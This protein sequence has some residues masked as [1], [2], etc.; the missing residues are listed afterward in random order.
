MFDPTWVLHKTYLITCKLPQYPSEKNVNK[1]NKISYFNNSIEWLRKNCKSDQE[2][3][4]KWYQ[5]LWE[6][7]WNVCQETWLTMLTEICCLTSLAWL[8]LAR[9]VSRRQLYTRAP[10]HSTAPQL[11]LNITVQRAE[12]FSSVFFIFGGLRSRHREWAGPSA[13]SPPL[14]FYIAIFEPLFD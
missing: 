14:Q 13:Y 3:I 10:T 12:H 8:W 9:R 1:S 2:K 4:L 5:F 6:D 11:S 7:D